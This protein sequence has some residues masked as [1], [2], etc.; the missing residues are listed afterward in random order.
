MDVV[1]EYRIRRAAK[2][3]D[4]EAAW[5]SPA[6][7]EADIMDI[8]EI[9]PESSDHHPRVA[10]KL[11]Y[12][13]DGL[14]GRFSVDDCYVKSRAEKFQDSV[15]I[16][17][18]VESF[19]QPAAGKGYV[20]VEINCGG[21]FLAQHVVD[22]TRVKYGFADYR[23]LTEDDV[24]GLRTAATMPKIN[25]PEITVPTHWEVGYFI[26]FRVYRITNGQ[27]I[28]QPGERWRGNFYKCAD[29]TS[30]PHWLS[31]N[32]LSRKN[33]HAPEDFGTLIFG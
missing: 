12:T 25:D 28:P 32:P 30:H 14:F 19:I 16:D 20:N 31:W 18:C 33:Y 9:R 6:W 26:P 4:I 5:D 23:P 7:A 13:D 2:S 1:K 11:L 17:S 21:V 10:L 27:G 3:P 24:A 22:P 8:S 15:C 29:R